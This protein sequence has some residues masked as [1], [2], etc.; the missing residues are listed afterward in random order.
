MKVIFSELAKAELDDATHYYE[1]EKQWDAAERIYREAVET[2]PKGDV[3]PLMELAAFY[4]R[5][6]AFDQ[7]LA[8][9]NKALIIQNND[10]KIRMKIAKLHFYFKNLFSV[11]IFPTIVF[12]KSKEFAMIC[13]RQNTY[14]SSTIIL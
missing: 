10:V 1:I 4:M 7:A 3:A 8:T 12:K 5:R 14:L 9:L 6:G 11:I 13:C 2:S